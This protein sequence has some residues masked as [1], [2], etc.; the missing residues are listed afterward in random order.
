MS[1]NVLITGGAGFIGSALIRILVTK[2]YNYSNIINLDLLTY[3]GDPLRLPDDKSIHTIT[4]DISNKELVTQVFADYRPI[5]VFHLAAESHVD[6]SIDG[7][8]A[9]VQTNIQGTLNLLQCATQ[10]WQDLS[11]SD[12]EIFRFVHVSTDE[13]YG[14]LGFDDEPFTEDSIYRPSSPYAATKASSDHLTYSWW[15]TFKLPTIITHCSNNYGPWQFPEKLIPLIISKALR[16]EKLPIYGDG[17]NIR[18]WIFVEDHVH[19]LLQI[20][21]NSAP[22][23]RWNI[24]AECEVSNLTLVHSLCDKLDYSKARSDNL[25]YRDLITFVDDRPGHDLR[26]AININ[27]LTSKFNWTPKTSFDQGLNQTVNW[28]LQ[29][30]D[31]VQGISDKANYTKQSRLGLLSSSS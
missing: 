14:S 6:R 2:N 30:Q 12:Q 18:D 24:G 25:S 5:I 27:K 15:K 31:W 20:S 10:Y 16:E 21:D 11:K 3:A 8:Q 17:S 26:Y 29:N 13:V 19:A 4:G 23:E 22:G 7:P 1:R 28:Y 9:F